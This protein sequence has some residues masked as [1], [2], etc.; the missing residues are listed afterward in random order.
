MYKIHT[1]TIKS[2]NSGSSGLSQ[3]YNNNDNYRIIR[4]DNNISVSNNMDNV[5]VTDTN[6]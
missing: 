6:K 2:N 1:I 3:Y 5:Q 4:Q